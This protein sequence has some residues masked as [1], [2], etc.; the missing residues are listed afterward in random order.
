MSNL[1]LRIKILESLKPIKPWYTIE[2][3][4]EATQAEWELI[5]DAHDNGRTVYVFQLRGDT[6]GVWLVDAKEIYWSDENNGKS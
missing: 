2:I 5:N 1:R 3:N 4:G 6:I